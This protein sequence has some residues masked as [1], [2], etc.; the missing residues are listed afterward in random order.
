MEV[1]RGN[2]TGLAREEVGKE[3]STSINSPALDVGG[4]KAINPPILS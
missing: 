1:L 2:E 3:N 4:C